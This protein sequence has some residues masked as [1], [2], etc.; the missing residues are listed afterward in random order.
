M[1]SMDP[2][3]PE[4][5]RDEFLE[6]A[7]L[8]AAGALDAAG[9]AGFEAHLQGGCQACE[10]ELRALEESVADLAFALPPREPR[11]G[12]RTRLLDRIAAPAAPV[13][14]PL[15]VLVRANQLEW[16]S[17]GVPGVMMKRLFVDKS[18]GNV[19]WLLKVEPGAVY[20]AHRH[21]GLE[22]TYV[23][24]GDVIFNDH[25]LDTGDYEVAMAT[26]AH[27]TVTSREGCLLLLINNERDEILC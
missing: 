6:L 7:P 13:P 12:L 24:D 14:N 26:T 15:S 27:S 21:A 17:A 20:P 19:T 2:M 23:I 4:T 1:N 9:A 16:R 18:T 22:H 8:Y 11:A 25:E 5:G 10:A 3:Q